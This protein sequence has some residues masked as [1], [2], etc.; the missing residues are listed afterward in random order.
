MLRDDSCIFM[1]GY[2]HP[3]FC[4]HYLERG[5]EGVGGCVVRAIYYYFNIYNIKYTISMADIQ[6]L[7][8]PFSTKD[9]SKSK[10]TSS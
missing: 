8:Y 6:V 5:G 2:H 4:E 10:I 7:V 3:L 1:H 9:R